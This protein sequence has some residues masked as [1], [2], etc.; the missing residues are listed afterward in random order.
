MIVV[1]WQLALSGWFLLF[2]YLCAGVV[3]EGMPG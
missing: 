1:F 3:R 2:A